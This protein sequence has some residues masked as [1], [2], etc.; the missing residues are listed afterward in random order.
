MDAQKGPVVERVCTHS[1]SASETPWPVVKWQPW[2]GKKDLT[3]A[4]KTDGGGK[5]APGSL[6]QDG[7]QKFN[8]GKTSTDLT[9]HGDHWRERLGWQE[10]RSF[11]CIMYRNLN[12]WP[13]DIVPLLQAV[14]SDGG[15]LA[16]RMNKK[17][18]MFP[19]PFDAFS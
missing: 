2:L 8:S 14:G 3:T 11:T 12:L 13:N 5:Q 4:L 18:V 6:E 19:Q 7:N 9:C 16:A 15:P 17:V 1:G 10:E